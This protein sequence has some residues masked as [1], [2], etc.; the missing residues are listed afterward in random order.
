MENGN[1]NE[2]R[3]GRWRGK[4]IKGRREES[5]RE[6][7]EFRRKTG[8]V[9]GKLDGDDGRDGMKLEGRG[10]GLEEGMTESSR[11]GKTEDYRRRY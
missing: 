10:E 5:N 9:G 1:E 3:A 8:M 11:K 4:E 7:R 2:R 6:R